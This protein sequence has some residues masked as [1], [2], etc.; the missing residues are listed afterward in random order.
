MKMPTINVGDSSGGMNPLMAGMLAGNNGNN[1]SWNNNPFIY[2]ILLAFLRNGGLF[3]DNAQ[4]GSAALQG[5]TASDV[6]ST[7]ELVLSGQANTSRQ[8][9]GVQGQIA[10]AANATQLDNILEGQGRQTVTLAKDISDAEAR[11]ADGQ[12]DIVTAV[13]AGI[14]R[15][16][17]GQGAIQTQ[18]A[19]SGFENQLG[20]QSLASKLAECCCAIQLG[21]K[22]IINTT[23]AGF[24]ATDAAICNQTNVLVA[25]GVANTQRILDRVNDIESLNQAQ[26]LNEAE[27]ELQTARTVDQISQRCGCCNTSN[28]GGGNGGGTNIDIINTAVALSRALTVGE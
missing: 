11:N 18:I 19:Q 6:Q 23:Q 27:R 16:R 3:G 14:A 4:G 10:N 12:R 22:D 28:G 2:L 8:I 26:K 1:D 9:E 25:Q 24:A 20:F 13:N 5:A 17:D 7:K 21:Q 15:V